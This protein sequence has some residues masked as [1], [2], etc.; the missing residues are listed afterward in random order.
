M[1][2]GVKLVSTKT[3]DSFVNFSGGGLAPVMFSIPYLYMTA[4]IASKR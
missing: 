2:L 4:P 3:E 1:N